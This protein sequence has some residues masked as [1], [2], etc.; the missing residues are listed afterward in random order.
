[1][2]IIGTVSTAITLA[3]R[4]RE[5]SKNIEDAEFKNLLAD[6]SNELADLKLEAAI[7]KERIVSLQEE[8]A[9]LSKTSESPHTK[10]TGRKWGCY[11]FAEDDGLYCP[12]CWDSKRKKSSTTRVN[13]RFR[14]CP[15]CNA[16]IGA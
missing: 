2:D 15:V 4:L 3:K 6:L 14:H 8:N 9:L 12:A 13:S 16:P 11:Q 7:L 1:M 5:I 10:P